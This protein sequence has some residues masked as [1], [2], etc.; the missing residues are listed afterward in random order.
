[1]ITSYLRL[2]ESRYGHEL[3]EDAESV[4]EFAVDG[5]VRM[6]KMIDGLLPFDG[7]SR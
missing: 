4:I 6:R 1:M 7:Y 5:A 3:D 2:I